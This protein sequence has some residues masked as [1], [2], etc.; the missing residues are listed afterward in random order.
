MCAE[1]YKIEESKPMIV[2]L[3]NTQVLS[4]I[5]RYHLAGKIVKID[6]DMD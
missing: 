3:G 4:P 5:G 1:F 2:V 6:I